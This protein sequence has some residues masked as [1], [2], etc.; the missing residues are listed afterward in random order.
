MALAS[1]G[2]LTFSSI[3]G[4]YG[5][6]NPI[7]ISEYYRNGDYVPNSIT[8]GTDSWAYPG[9]VNLVEVPDTSQNYWTREGNFS[10]LFLNGSLVYSASPMFFPFEVALGGQPPA[11]PGASYVQTGFGGTFQT[12]GDVTYHRVAQATYNAYQTSSQTTTLVNQ[13]VPIDGVISVS[14]FYNGRKT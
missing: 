8:T 3:Q 6:A 7:N 9:Y 14:N 4:E 1:S 13:V 11:G 2:P 12:I 5:G 10:Q